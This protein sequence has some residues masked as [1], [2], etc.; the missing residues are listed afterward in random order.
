[1]TTWAAATFAHDGRR[2]LE[3]MRVLVGI[4]QDADD[5]YLVTADLLCHVAIEIFRGQ[6]RDFAAGRTGVGEGRNCD[7]K[8]G[9]KPEGRPH[10]KA[11]AVWL[12]IG[13]IQ[14]FACYSLRPK[15]NNI[16]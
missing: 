4:A 5:R 16:T 1:M 13:R 11:S 3:Q 10:P 7:Q 9:Y 6:D 15:C 14:H 12:K 2:G 8:R